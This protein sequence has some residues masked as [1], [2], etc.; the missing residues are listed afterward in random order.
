MFLLNPKF[1]TLF[2]FYVKTGI[3]FHVVSWIRIFNIVVNK[4]SFMQHLHLPQLQTMVPLVSALLY[5]HRIELEV[6]NE[7][8]VIQIL[9]ISKHDI[10][11]R[12][13]GG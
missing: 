7:L 11:I 9:I 10:E 13:H 4:A 6:K 3:I 8:C 1:K 5:L 12:L 2:I